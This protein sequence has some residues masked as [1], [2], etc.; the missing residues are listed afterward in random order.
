MSK[1]AKL[2]PTVDELLKTRQDTP[3]RVENRAYAHASSRALDKILET[4]AGPEGLSFFAGLNSRN[5][6]RSQWTLLYLAPAF[7]S[8]ASPEERTADDF[9]F[10]YCSALDE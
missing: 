5:L 7:C 2:K 4:T 1:R 8:T 6:G 3:L 9:H 10:F